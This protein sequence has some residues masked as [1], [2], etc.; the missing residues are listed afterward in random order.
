M[1]NPSRDDTRRLLKTFGIAAD[2]AILTHLARTPGRSRVVRLTLED[3]TDYGD[4]APDVPLHLELEGE[5]RA[6]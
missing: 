3:L 4:S 5:I 6:A 2:E 1:D